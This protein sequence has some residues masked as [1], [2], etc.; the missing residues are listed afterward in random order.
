M[1]R[2][3]SLLLLSAC[4]AK[5]PVP[6][7]ERAAKLDWASTPILPSPTAGA[8]Q[9]LPGTPRDTVVKVLADGLSFDH[10][11][12][13][14]AAA[15]ALDAVDGRGGL[16][17]WELR[18]AMWRGGWPYPVTEARGW[19]ALNND[20]PPPELLTWLEGIPAEQPMALVRARG[21]VGDAWIGVHA[22]PEVDLPILPRRAPLGTPLDLPALA[23]ASYRLADGGGALFE[24]PL[25]RGERLLLTSAGEW[26]LQINVGEREV[27]KA[28]IYV[29]LEPPETP[30]LRL[31]DPP[32]IGTAED[33]NAW[34]RRLLDHVRQTYRLRRWS[35]DPMLDAAARTMALQPE[36]KPLDV[37]AALGFTRTQATV[38]DCTDA[39]VEHCLDRWVW[40]PRR[41]QALLSTDLDTVG[42][43]TTL[44][45]RGVRLLL[46]LAATG[47]TAWAP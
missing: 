3:A 36:R 21:R 5:A 24:G 11:L 42:L 22:A 38:W 10:A 9:R 25:D 45:P 39:T 46:V 30:L 44:G 40:D 43:Y 41:R 12:E 23:G 26:L 16:Q 19:D 13:A 32:L 15:L 31:P 34:A 37:L 17:R 2:L 27:A 20:P 35:S 6:L 1:T 8:Y 29:S 4:A 47:T 28:P 18:E 7:M 14:G 33:A